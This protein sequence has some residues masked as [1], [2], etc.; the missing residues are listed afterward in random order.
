MKVTTH[1]MPKSIKI[2]SFNIPKDTKDLEWERVK[3]NCDG[4]NILVSKLDEIVRANCPYRTVRSDSFFV[5]RVVDEFGDQVYV[6]YAIE[7]SQIE[8]NVKKLI[9]KSNK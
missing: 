2:P 5:R 6:Y 1:N 3:L 8:K 4:E 9:K 7:L